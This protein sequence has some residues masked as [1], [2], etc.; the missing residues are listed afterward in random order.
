MKRI[1]L[2]MLI[3]MVVSTFGAIPQVAYG[4]DEEEETERLTLLTTD[5]RAFLIEVSEKRSAIWFILQMYKE[6]YK[7]TY[8]DWNHI[9]AVREIFTANK[10]DCSVQSS[11]AVFADVRAKWNNEVCTAFETFNSFIV[12]CF[13]DALEDPNW[14]D[15]TLHAD[16]ISRLKER[17][18]ELQ[19]DHDK[20]MSRIQEVSELADYRVDEL[21]Q[22]R[23]VAEGTVKPLLEEVKDE[24]KKKEAEAGKDKDKNTATDE[25]KDKKDSDDLFSC[26]IA[27]AAYGSPEAAEIDTLRRFRDEFLV[28][29]YPGRA[30]VAA[31]YATSPPVAAFISEHEMLR[32][33]VREG[34]V[35]PV[36]NVLELTESWWAE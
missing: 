15:P 31:Y 27:T 26:F 32:V 35:A 12:S 24:L 28:Y 10:P 17:L 36:V 13:D 18:S 22:A 29:N 34:F 1:L 19:P 4:D 23:Q 30:F 33:A 9:A 25:D 2:F 8:R 14:A 6:T 3:I 5:E 20:I 21:I 7:T 11:P 16:I